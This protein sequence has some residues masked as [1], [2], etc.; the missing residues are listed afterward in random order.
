MPGDVVRRLT[1]A[2]TQRGYCREIHVKAD[3]KIIGNSR[4]VI[5]DVSSDRLVP[6]ISMPRDNAVCL[7]AW[8]GST[9][10]I[11]EKLTL[12]STCGSIL[13]LRPDIDY[14]PFKD[15]N[16]K[17]L[18]SNNLF[19]VGQQLIGPVNELD[20]AKWLIQTPEMRTS[21]KHKAERKFTIQAVEVDGVYVHWQC[22]ASC[23]ENSSSNDS[24]IPKSYITGDDLK[25]MKRLNLFESCMLQINDKNYLT[26]NENDNV[27]RKS[28]WKKEQS[29]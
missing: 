16:N 6:L 22:K 25:R 26:I 5:R 7:D 2:D 19:Y 17:S 15:K 4:Y 18:F 24:G 14:F 29:K 12:K 10:N 11:D 21:R 1:N 8:V 28:L 3:L 13:E 20:N 23:D 9:K 27:V